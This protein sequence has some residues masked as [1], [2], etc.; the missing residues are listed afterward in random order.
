MLDEI[1][2][3][4]SRCGDR[5]AVYVQ[6]GEG[7]RKSDPL[8]AVDERMVLGER[9]PKRGGLLQTVGIVAAL[10]PIRSR[11]QKTGIAQPL[12]AAVSLDQVRVDGK[13]IGN[14]QEVR[15]RA[16]FLY[17]SPYLS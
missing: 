14:G 7:R 6:K 4:I 17:S 8:V 9:F 2:R 1:E 10:R 3:G 11:F 16:S 5:N 12:R 13:H 15:H